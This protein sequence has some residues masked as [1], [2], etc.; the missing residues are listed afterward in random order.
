[1]KL[2]II[3][4][5]VTCC[6]YTI[7]TI[8]RKCHDMIQ[9][10]VYQK[11][12]EL[13]VLFLAL[14]VI[15]GCGKTTP[16]KTNPSVY[17]IKIYEYDGDFSELFEEWKSIGINT[18]FASVEL[19][20]DETFRSLALK[21]SITRF[22]ILP[23]FYDPDVLKE[24]PEWYAITSKGEKAEDSWV[25][26]VCPSCEEFRR[27]KVDYIARITRELNPDGLSIDF[28]RHFVYWEQVYPDRTPESIM[29][30]CFDSRCIESFQDDTG[31]SIPENLNTPDTRAAWIFENHLAEWSEWKCG[32]IASMLEDIVSEAKKIKPDIKINIHTV[33]WR[34]KDFN[35]AIKIVA[36]QDFSKL[37]QLADY[38]SPMTYSH[39]VRQ[40][41]EWIHS[42]VEDIA[43][44]A[45]CQ[46]VPSIQVGN[47]A[48]TLDQF[49]IALD[50]SLMPP[51]QGVVFWSWDAL[52]RSPEKKETVK[53]YIVN[54]VQ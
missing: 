33:P 48:F 53:K 2:Y 30:T 47:D 3:A 17:G 8:N 5:S 43:D 51:S 14:F 28:M 36:G 10:A 9:F 52:A 1:M 44:Q 38:L 22:V 16:S 25:R 18:V 24:H 40:P 20:T 4:Y 39:M 54:S 46:V 42:V 12:S 34:R 35:G 23:T 31:I 32:L 13:V 49:T 41:P 27:Y 11:F 26:F 19:N 45:V 50:A 29:N 6:S 7:D 15:N 37:S 21:Y